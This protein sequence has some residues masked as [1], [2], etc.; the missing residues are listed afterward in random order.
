MLTREQHDAV[1]TEGVERVLELAQ[2]AGDVRERQRREPAEPGR[3]VGHQARGDLVT[4]P[5]EVARGGRIA[6]VD[7]GRR[8]GRDGGLDA[9]PVH[10]AECIIDAPARERDTATAGDAHASQRRDVLAR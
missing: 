5:R 4:A 2:R 7:A 1:E 8:D 6:E 9:V 3:V 10:Q